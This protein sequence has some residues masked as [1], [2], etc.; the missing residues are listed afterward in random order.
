MIALGEPRRYQ[1]DQQT[2][3][4]PSRKDAKNRAIRTVFPA[5]QLVPRPHS[6]TIHAARYYIYGVSPF[7]LAAATSL[8]GLSAHAASSDAAN[9][10]T[11]AAAVLTE[12]DQTA[13]DSRLR[14]GD[15]NAD[16]NGNTDGNDDATATGALEDPAVAA[17]KQSALGDGAEAEAGIGKTPNLK[18]FHAQVTNW[19]FGP[20][21]VDVQNNFA[22]LE[23]QLI[24][25]RVLPM[26]AFEE[27]SPPALNVALPQDRVGAQH[28]LAHYSNRYREMKQDGIPQVQMV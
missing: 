9:V 12:T 8:A 15:E 10:E 23:K 27:T 3:N 18:G 14:A 7:N 26:L 6:R 16:R 4:E 13:V 28:L 20:G 2:K 17:M 1:V 5:N 11:P 25:A 24:Q 22:A 19:A 21:H